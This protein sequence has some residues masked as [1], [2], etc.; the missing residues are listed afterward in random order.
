MFGLKSLFAQSKPIQYASYVFVLGLIVLSKFF[1][2]ENQ[3]LDAKLP[4]ELPASVEIAPSIV[5]TVDKVLDG[6]TLIAGGVRY[7]LAFIDAPEN[8]QAYG[9][10]AASFLRALVADSAIT[11]TERGKDR[12]GRTIAEASING[13]CIAEMM[14]ENGYAWPYMVPTAE[15]ENKLFHLR[16][17]ARVGELG[18]WTDSNPIQPAIHR[19][20]KNA[21]NNQ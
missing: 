16:E 11:L 10:E 8:D 15:M 7:R 5:A 3:A 13:I 17:K 18:L 19:Q 1:P 21:A 12:Y 6:D 4:S 20:I 9:Q 14:I 2:G